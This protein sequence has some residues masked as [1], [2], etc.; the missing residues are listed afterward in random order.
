[1]ATNFDVM[2]NISLEPTGLVDFN[3]NGKYSQPQFTWIL[4]TAPTA[5]K[6]F[7]S[8]RYGPDYENDLFVA[9]ANT[10]SVYHFELN[11]NRTALQLQPPLDDKIANNMEE[12]EKIIFAKGFGRITD[13]QIGPDGYLY[14]LSSDDGIELDRIIPK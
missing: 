12:Q 2:G 5:L 4:P 6:F 9:D 13:M 3:G 7:A 8:T 1:M 14:I 10:G 11:N